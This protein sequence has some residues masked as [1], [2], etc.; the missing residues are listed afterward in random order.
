VIEEFD[1]NCRMTNFVICVLHKILFVCS[2][3]YYLCAPQNTICVLHQI[4]FVLHKILF[5]CS[6]KYYLCAPQNIICV[7]HKLLDIQ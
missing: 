1:D 2:T 6:T 5:V 7:L 4:L 3:K